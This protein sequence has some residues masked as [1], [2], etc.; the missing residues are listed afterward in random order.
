MFSIMP[1]DMLSLPVSLSHAI[2]V[3]VT[4][5]WQ[6]SIAW[7]ICRWFLRISYD[8]EQACDVDPGWKIKN[9]SVNTIENCVLK[10]LFMLSRKKKKKRKDNCFTTQVW[11][12]S[13]PHNSFPLRVSTAWN[14]P[15]P[16]LLCIMSTSIL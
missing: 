4:E 6:Q 3:L 13:H 2:I 15:P 9:I 10:C 12:S 7:I 1:F 16:S 14:D 8:D 5:N 11:T